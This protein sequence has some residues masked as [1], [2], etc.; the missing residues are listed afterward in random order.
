MSAWTPADAAAHNSVLFDR[1]ASSLRVYKNA[2]AAGQVEIATLRA[3]LAELRA[4]TGGHHGELEAWKQRVQD[5]NDDVRG[6]VLEL[7]TSNELLREA[8]LDRE[9]LRAELRRFQEFRQTSTELFRSG[10]P[11]LTQAQTECPED[12]PAVGRLARVILGDHRY[13][14]GIPPD[15]QCTCAAS[16]ALKGLYEARS[17]VYPTPRRRRPRRPPP[18]PLPT[19]RQDVQ[20]IVRPFRQL[21]VRPSLNE[22]VSRMRENAGL[23]QPSSPAH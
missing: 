10:S 19:A 9:R 16:R 4:Q 15:F 20:T 11:T 8:E 13:T 2:H 23:L 12:D 7:A 14:I 17:Q 18:L 1:Y 22:R 21:E 5:L 3:A 6:R